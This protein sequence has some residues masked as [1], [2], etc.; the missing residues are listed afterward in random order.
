MAISL[1]T[2]QDYNKSQEKKSKSLKSVG[3][4]K[5]KT[6]LRQTQDKLETNL[7][8]TQDKPKTK[9]AKLETQPKTQPKTNLRQTQD[10]LETNLRQTNNVYELVGIQKNI[11]FFICNICIKTGN[12]TTPPLTINNI[13]EGSNCKASSIRKTVQ[14]LENIKLISRYKHKAGR[15]AWT[16][17]S[18]DKLTYSDLLNLRQTQDKPET[19][20]RQTQ[21]K[22]ETQPK[23][24][25]ETNPPSS[26]S[27]NINTITREG[28]L[29]IDIPQILKEYKFNENILIKTT[30]SNH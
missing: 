19:N 18:I 16:Q 13:A 9:F 26:S 21:D 28:F 12:T 10:K 24:Q 4:T 5:L 11:M 20:L 14:R 2:F 27:N 22:L 17:Y 23:T 6:N 29:K 7:R 30:L 1:K 15:G 25:L 8:Q 3:Y